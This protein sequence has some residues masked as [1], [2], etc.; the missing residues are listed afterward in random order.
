MSGKSKYYVVWKG[1]ER[2]VYDNWA[3][4]LRRTQGFEGAQYKSFATREEAERAF[5]E[6]PYEHLG[7]TPRRGPQCRKLSGPASRRAWPSMRRAAATQATWSIAVC[8]WPAAASSST[9]A[10][11]RRARTTSASFWPLSTPWPSV[12]RR[13]RP[14]YRSTPTA[15]TPL[16]GSSSVTVAR[17]SHRPLPMPPS[18]TSSVVPRHGSTPTPTPTPS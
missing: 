10:R 16:R 17:S 4:C 13:G 14:S 15:A 3:D 12:P 11:W 8:M 7:R 9:S 5:S 2:G 18:L 1:V 6:S